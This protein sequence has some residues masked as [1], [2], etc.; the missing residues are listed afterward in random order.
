YS[1]PLHPLSLPEDQ[2]ILDCQYCSLSVYF[3]V[4]YNEKLKQPILFRKTP[5]HKITKYD[6]ESAECNSIEESNNFYATAGLVG[7]SI[8]ED[9]RCLGNMKKETSLA[10]TVPELEV[11]V[12]GMVMK[13]TIDICGISTSLL[14]EIFPL[15]VDFC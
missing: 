6:L 3:K 7:F 13:H 8:N 1:M 11:I 5:I 9:M 2:N 14:N 4:L 15:P 12:A 10:V